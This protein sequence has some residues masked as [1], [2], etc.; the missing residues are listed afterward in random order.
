M[1]MRVLLATS[2]WLSMFGM[3]TLYAAEGTPNDQG[4]GGTWRFIEAIQ[5]T[6]LDPEPSRFNGMTITFAPQVVEG[7]VPFGCEDARYEN[8]A[9]PLQG[10]FQGYFEGEQAI[11][12]AQRFELPMEIDTL[13]VDCD[14]GTFD[15]HGGSGRMLIMLDGV[16]HILER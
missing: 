16:I 3:V 9:V 11:E 13:R 12:F 14:T 15:Y 4:F 10:L 5:L 6:E 2:G 7:P 1:I 8:I